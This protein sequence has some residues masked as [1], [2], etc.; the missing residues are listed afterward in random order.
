MRASLLRSRRAVGP[1]KYF[2]SRS[3][4][5]PLRAEVHLPCQTAT[6]RTRWTLV[7]SFAESDGEKRTPECPS[8]GRQAEW[9]AGD[10]FYG[11][12]S[13]PFRRRLRPNG[14]P[15]K[16][17]AAHA[18]GPGELV[19]EPVCPGSVQVTRDGQCIVIGVDGQTI[20]GYP[21][22]SQVI[23]A[24]IDKLARLRPGEEVRFRSVSLETAERLYRQKCAGAT[25]VADAPPHGGVSANEARWLPRPSGLSCQQRPRSPSPYHRTTSHAEGPDRALALAPTSEG[26]HLQILREAGFELVFPRISPPSAHRGRVTRSFAR[27]A[28]RVDRGHG[29]PTPRGVARCLP[30]GFALVIARVGVGYDAVDVPAATSRGVAVTIAPGTNQDSVAE[31]TFCFILGFPRA[32]WPPSTTP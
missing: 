19:S 13:S 16:G 31:H 25:R 26:K 6:T 27:R 28:H 32:A 1:R 11:R 10:D 30:D 4:L 8:P 22:V 7:T 18:A 9:F 2:G 21:K 12:T 17:R 24:D 20:G 14:P 5:E 29:N 15:L 3:G 23:A